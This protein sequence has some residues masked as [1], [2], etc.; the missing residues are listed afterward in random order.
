M[1]IL[2]VIIG[3]VVFLFSLA[4]VRWTRNLFMKLI[5]A[6]FILVNPVTT[7]VLTMFLTMFIMQIIGL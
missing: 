2:A 7:I 6:N 3:I 5:G 1:E 4:I